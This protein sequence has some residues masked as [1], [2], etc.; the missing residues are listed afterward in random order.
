MA[1]EVP[2][3]PGCGA[4]PPT[5]RPGMVCGGCGREPNEDDNA[6]EEVDETSE[7]NPQAEADIEVPPEFD[8]PPETD[9]LR[10]APSAEAGRLHGRD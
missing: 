3:C 7:P 4:T 10:E 6:A 9:L 1:R 2:T 8:A 5:F